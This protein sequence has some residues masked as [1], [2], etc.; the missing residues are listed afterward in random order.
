MRCWGQLKSLRARSVGEVSS[1]R[2]CENESQP[3]LQKIRKAGH[4]PG[5]ERLEGNR[6]TIVQ[7]MNFKTEF[8]QICFQCSADFI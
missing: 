5:G 1:Y 6:G 8:I 7:H 3:A 4:A 2:I